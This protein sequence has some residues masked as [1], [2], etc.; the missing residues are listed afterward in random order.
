MKEKFEK[1]EI[2]TE[3]LEAEVL[4]EAVGSPGPPVTTTTQI[5]S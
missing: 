5:P 2:T 1:P 4:F 3:V